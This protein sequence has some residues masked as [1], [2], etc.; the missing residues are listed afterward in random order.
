MGLIA[1]FH[2]VRRVFTT[3]CQ[4]DVEAYIASKNPKNASEVEYW[5]QQYTY[6][7]QC[8]GPFFP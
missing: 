5:L 4:T 8:H 1:L 2:A 3:G 7:N 6:S